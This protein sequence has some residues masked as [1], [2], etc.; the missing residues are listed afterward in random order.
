MKIH[1]LSEDIEEKFEITANKHY[2]EPK[3]GQERRRLR[4][5]RERISKK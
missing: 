5:K 1:R 2:E 4:R 3:S